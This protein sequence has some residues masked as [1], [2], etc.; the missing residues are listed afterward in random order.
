MVK[1]TA[2]SIAKK[3][4]VR[5]MNSLNKRWNAIN[6]DLERKNESKLI[7]Q[8]K[9]NCKSSIGGSSGFL[10]WILRTTVDPLLWS[11]QPRQGDNPLKGT[12]LPLTKGTTKDH[13][14]FKLIN[15]K[16]KK[17]GGPSYP[18]SC[19]PRFCLSLYSKPAWSNQNKI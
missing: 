18:R 3:K 9:K 12:Y 6:L 13:L 1:L 11:W 16:S 14:R 5:V 4:L 7:L 2:E 8:I 15:H 10:N 19:Y 17:E